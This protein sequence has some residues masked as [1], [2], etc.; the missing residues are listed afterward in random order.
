[1]SVVAIVIAI[2]VA[3]I[4]IKQAKS[5]DQPAT[6]PRKSQLR[7]VHPVRIVRIHPTRVLFGLAQATI[8]YLAYAWVVTQIL[9]TKPPTMVELVMPLVD[10]ALLGVLLYWRIPSAYMRNYR[11]EKK[12]K[13]ALDTLVLTMTLLLMFGTMGYHMFVVYTLPS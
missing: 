6:A 5:I 2:A 9:K 13:S 3:A 11:S 8:L 10:M 7:P 12:S 4:L 1:M